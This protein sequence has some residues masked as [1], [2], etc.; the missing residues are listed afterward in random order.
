MTL[1]DIKYEYVINLTKFFVEKYRDGEIKDLNLIDKNVIAMAPFITN[2]KHT[3]DETIWPP[4]RPELYKNLHREKPP[5]YIVKTLIY[6][7][8][9]SAAAAFKMYPNDKKYTFD[10]YWEDNKN[11]LISLYNDLL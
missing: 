9:A 2:F 11:Y 10:Q 1:N 4:T 5:E 6:P 8:W 3:F 7:A